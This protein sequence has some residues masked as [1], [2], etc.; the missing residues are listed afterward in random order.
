M[1]LP[2]RPICNRKKSA[3]TEP[4]LYRFSIATVLKKRLYS[5]RRS[6]YPQT[7]GQKKVYVFR[8]NCLPPLERRKPG[9]PN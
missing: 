9:M 5:T 1:L 6:Q 7:S 3:G 4:V 2:I 8:T